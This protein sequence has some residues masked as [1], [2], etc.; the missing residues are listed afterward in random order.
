MSSVIKILPE[1]LCNKIAAGEVVERPSSVVKELVENSLDAGARSIRIDIEGGGKRLLRV[2]DDG[3]G[4]VQDDALMCLERHATSKIST[5]DDLFHLSSFGF[6]GEALPSIASVSRLT[7]KSCASEAQGGVEL[8]AEGGQVK[9][10]V[11]TGMPRGTIIEIRSL[12]FNTPARRKFL[13]RDETELAHVQDVVLKLALSSPQTQ[14]R[15]YHNDRLLIDT[16][17]SKDLAER[18]ASLLGRATS[19]ELLQL[20]SQ[21]S[22]NLSIAGYLSR[23]DC[24]RST[25]SAVYTFIN[26]RYIRDKVVQHAIREGYRTLLPKGRYPVTVL[27]ISLDPTQVDVNVHP[28]KHEVR[29]REQSRIHDFIASSIARR[30]SPSDWVARAATDAVGETGQDEDLSSAPP[31]PP[32]APAMPVSSPEGLWVG[33]QL[34]SYRPRI[35]TS[36]S[37]AS[38]VVSGA[39]VDSFSP[40]PVASLEPVAVDC[41]ELPPAEASPGFFASLQVLGQY[42][43]SYILCQHEG[44]LLLIDQH[45]AHERIRFEELKGQFFSGCLSSQALLFPQIIEMSPADAELLG[46]H[47][48]SLLRLGLEIEPFGGNAFAIKSV[49]ALHIEEDVERLVRDLIDDISTQGASFLVE[50]AIE[51]TLMLMACHGV[52]RARQPLSEVQIRALLGAMDAVD[53]NSHCPHGRPV[54]VRLSSREIEKMFKRT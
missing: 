43:N 19:R 24:S 47:L 3:C 50:E 28:T 20:E 6:R 8:Y 46:R 31:T 25:G 53:F 51:S 30:M 27:F 11:E 9:R 54:Q 44:D 40:A 33:E 48:T 41:V 34:A 32:H 35:G 22:D 29:F 10:V 1:Q 2:S 7:L 5:D 52:V 26:G 38:S 18:I 36:E 14:F 45:A 23:P 12:F 13:R 42:S 37:K 49:P 15:L 17:A 16:P 21:G 4:M 39:S